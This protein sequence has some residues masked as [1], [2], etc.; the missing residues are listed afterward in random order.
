MDLRSICLLCAALSLAA[1]LPTLAADSPGQDDRSQAMSL[2]AQPEDSP[3]GSF[4]QPDERTSDV[5]PW[6]RGPRPGLLVGAGMFGEDALRIGVFE[7]RKGKLVLLASTQV[8]SPDGMDHPWSVEVHLDLIRYELRPG[9]CAF[10]VRYHNSYN[11]TARFSDTEALY[12]Y[13]LVGSEL[14]LAFEAL[15]FS[16]GG[17]KSEYP[18]ET[19]AQATTASS[20]VVVLTKT[21]HDGFYD[22]LL[23]NGTTKATRTFVWNG[24]SY[25]EQEYQSSKKPASRPHEKH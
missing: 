11:S 12:L 4:T 16:D 10:G 21:L 22:L 18:E 17:D 1:P 8:E 25:A 14:Q 15:T 20:Y 13:R 9:E 3:N 24:T 5:R 23:R 19:E 2:L 7:R 6:D